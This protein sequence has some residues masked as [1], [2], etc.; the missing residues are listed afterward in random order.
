MLIYFDLFFVLFS[1][2][3][4]VVFAIRLQGTVSYDGQHDPKQQSQGKRL[5]AMH[6][7][8]VSQHGQA[9]VTLAHEGKLLPLS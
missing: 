9:Q 2:L 8:L 5:V 6:H 4:L 3:L 7:W 1:W